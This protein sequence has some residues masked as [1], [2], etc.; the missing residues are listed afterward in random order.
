AHALDLH[1]AGIA[2]AAREPVILTRPDD[3]G[4]AA[5]GN[6]QLDSSHAGETSGDQVTNLLE[7]QL[8]FL[9]QTTLQNQQVLAR[10]LDLLREL[11][12]RNH[13]PQPATPPVEKIVGNG[14]LDSVSEKRATAGRIGVDG[15]IEPEFFIPYQPIEK[16][17]AERLEREQ[18]KHL[19]RLIERVTNRT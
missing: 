10:Q 13:R 19:S 2:A 14:R 8:E 7:K 3:R 16:T 11:G 1:D 12:T 4:L 9:R 15:E 18:S 17:A 5:S 6:F